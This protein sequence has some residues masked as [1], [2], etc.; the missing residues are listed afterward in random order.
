VADARVNAGAKTLA[1]VE[2][3]ELVDLQR[4]GFRLPEDAKRLELGPYTFERAEYRDPTGFRTPYWKR[5]A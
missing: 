1:D 4:F 2:V 5:I 3:G